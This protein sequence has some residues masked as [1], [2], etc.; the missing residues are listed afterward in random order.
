M[1]HFVIGFLDDY[2]DEARLAEIRRVAADY[3]GT[4]L[5]ATTFEELSGRVSASTIQ[6]KLGGWRPALEAAGFGHLYGGRRVSS[7]M[8]AQAA[9]RMTN[10]ELLAE[11]RK[12]R[13]RVGRS[14]LTSKD[15]DVHSSLV[16]SSVIRNRFGSWNEALHAAGI[17]QSTMANKNWTD[18]DCY[19][20]LADVWTQ[21]GRQP[22]YREMFEPP[23]D[24]RQGVR[25]PLG[26][27]A[28]SAQ[29]IRRMGKRRG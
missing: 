21:L 15:F 25:N 7:K 16:S 5:S 10:D 2:S 12:V 14:V 11:M 6:R 23:G 24:Q 29:G 22:T 13:E 27:L 26:D 9:R 20:D 3:R 8:K 18:E 1:S 4:T 17:P 19:E 28:E